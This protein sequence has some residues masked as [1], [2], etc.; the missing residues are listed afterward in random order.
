MG[1]VKEHYMETASEKQIHD[2]E[3]NIMEDIAETKLSHMTNFT[4]FNKD[5]LGIFHAVV[6]FA[7]KQRKLREYYSI[8]IIL[9]VVRFHTD[10]SGTGDPYKINNNYKPYY[11]RMYMQYRKC[12]G[13]FQLRGSLADEYDYCPDIDYYKEWLDEKK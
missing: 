13:F 1:R 12:P 11:A 4:R 7:D 3:E 8:E 2:D 5:N 9:N 10:L 6:K